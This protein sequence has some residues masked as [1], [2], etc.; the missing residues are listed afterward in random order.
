MALITG[1]A[2]SATDGWARWRIHAV[3]E[4]SW[5]PFPPRYSWTIWIQGWFLS[6]PPSDSPI[7]NR[8]EPIDHWPV[9]L[10][11]GAVID[12]TMTLDIGLIDDI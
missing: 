5:D 2:F 8:G 3:R 7:H 6:L 9:D 10:V 1:G 12:Q 11:V 4:Q